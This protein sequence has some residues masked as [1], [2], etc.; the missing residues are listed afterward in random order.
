MEAQIPETGDELASEAKKKTLM[1][2]CTA[3]GVNLKKWLN[4][5]GMNMDNLTEM[6]CASLLA[7]LKKK[8][9]DD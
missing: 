4:N 3:H 5:N 1:T 6:Q 9:G 7:V 8:F 2:Q